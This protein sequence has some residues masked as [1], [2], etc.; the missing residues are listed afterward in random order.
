M[1]WTK[2]ATE[3]INGM[4]TNYSLTMLSQ[5]ARQ[6]IETRRK[7]GAKA[8]RAFSFRAFIGD[9]VPLLSESMMGDAALRAS[10][11]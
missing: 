4:V 8:V 10:S 6:L 7:G 9:L 1:D 5:C 2:G 11:A 3:A